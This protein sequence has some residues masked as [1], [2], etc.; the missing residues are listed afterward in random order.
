MKIPNFSDLS[1]K[2]MDALLHPTT[3]LASHRT[4]GPLIL[5]RGKGIHVWD[6]AGRQYVDGMAGLW[7]TALGYGEQELVAAA[8]EQMAR[9]SYS[10]LF[11]GRSNEPSILLAEKL[12]SLAPFNV[13]KVFFG[14]S[15]SDAN[16]TQIKFM[17]YYNNALGRG[18][19]K[20]IIS[21]QRGYHGVTVASA[22][23]T[24]LRSS[25]GGFDVPLSGFL[26]VRCP[27]FYREGI[28][29]ESESQFLDRLITELEQLIQR[30]GPETI[31][32]FIA[33][34]ALGAGGVVVPPVGY[35]E[36]IQEVLRR[37]EILLIDDEVICGFGRTGTLFGCESVGMT[38]DTMSV[39]KSLSSGYQPISAVLIPDRMYDA[40]EAASRENGV[41]GHGFTYSGH[42]V[43][44]A[45]ALRNLEVIEKRGI[46]AH[47]AELSPFF[48]ADLRKFGDHQ[49]VGEAR[50]IGLVGALELVSDKDTR[51]PFPTEL[52]VGKLLQR[53]CEHHG[54][55]IRA[56][57]DTTVF[58]PPLIITRDE[59]SRIF[60]LFSNAISDLLEELHHR[61]ALRAS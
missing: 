11:N 25:H 54:L 24:G 28:V 13:S 52:G 46:I 6:E 7:C 34:P 21:H 57:G 59:I 40:F 4:I 50:G 16:D 47:A 17:W 5:N 19:K 14:H 1:R 45:V 48:Q 33:E 53:C 41:F 30:E 49:L 39:A 2:D 27:H 58:C 3:E 35:Y 38:P 31:A 10:H 23:L 9:L 56:L 60:S 18:Q 22:S 32:A 36:R 29:G 42:P 51:R 44:A 20:K 43:A 37:H 26:R 61:G 8:S 12:K 55:L 15:G